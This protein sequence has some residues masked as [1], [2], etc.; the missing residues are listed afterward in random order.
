M[1]RYKKYPG[2]V[3]DYDM[4]IVGELVVTEVKEK[5]SYCE[6]VSGKVEKGMT[7]FPK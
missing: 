1:E 4:T 5:I 7:V 6:I 2:E 3:L